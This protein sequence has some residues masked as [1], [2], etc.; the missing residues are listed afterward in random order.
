MIRQQ[1]SMKYIL[2]LLLYLLPTYFSN[3]QQ[4]YFKKWQ[5]I[6]SLEKKGLYGTALEKVNL[7][8]QSASSQNNTNQIIKS[9]IYQLKYN[10]YIAEDDYVLAINHLNTIIPTFQS[11]TK[12]ILH[13]I[14]AEVYYG[15]YNQNQWK[16]S[17]RTTIADDVKIGDIRT[18]DLKRLSQSIIYHYQASLKHE[19]INAAIP[20]KTFDTFIHSP[21]A[22]GFDYYTVYDFLAQRAFSF[23]SNNSF[24]IE[25]PAQTFLIDT[26]DYFGSNTTF[27]NLK[28]TTPDSLN[29]KFYAAQTLQAL[30]I[31][32]TKKNSPFANFQ[33]ALKRLK[34]AKTHSILTDKK[35]RYTEAIKR[36]TINYKDHNFVGEAWYEIANDMY[37]DGIGYTPK[38]SS[39]E[40]HFL[41]KKSALICEEIIMKFPKSLGARQCQSLLSQIKQKELGVSTEATY[42]PNKKANFLIKYRNIDQAYAK[43]VLVDSEKKFNS[44]ELKSFLKNEPGLHLD[45]IVL[46]GSSDYLSHSTEILLP[47]LELGYYYV[48]LSSSVDFSHENSGLAY[49]NFW[50]TKLAYQ[51]KP[52]SNSLVFLGMCRQTGHPIEGAEIK[53]M[54]SYYNRTLSRYAEKTIG[55]YKTDEKGLVTISEI[56]PNQ[57]YFFSMKSGEDYYSPQKSVYYYNNQHTPDKNTRISL[58]TDRKLYRPGQTIYFKGIVVENFQDNNK[59]LPNFETQIS[60]YDVNGEQVESIPLKANEFGS[61]EGQFI[62]PYG[63]LTGAMTIQSS[64]GST[65]VQVEEYKRPKFSCEIDPVKGEYQLNDS[66]LISGNAEAFAGNK[67]SDAKV[68]Y[69]V[70]RTTRYNYWY[71]WFRPSVSKE[72]LNG[73]T[74]TNEKGQFTFKFKAIP[75]ESR[76]PKDLPIFNYTITIDVIDINGETHSSS[77]TFALGYQSLVLSNTIKS[78][79]NINED[80]SFEIKAAS[81]N[82]EALETTGTFEI[83]KLKTP[84]RTYTKRLWSE[85]DQSQWSKTEFYELFPN[86]AYKN[87]NDF[88][89]WPTEKTLLNQAFNTKSKAKITI[90]N[91]AKW[92]PGRYQY[93]AESKDKNGVIVKDIAYF[94]VFDSNSKAPSLNH[95]FNAKLVK[96]TVKPGQTAEVILSSAAKHLNVYYSISSKGKIEHQEWLHLKTEQRKI[97]IPIEDRHIGKVNLDIIV[98]K[99]NRVYNKTLNVNVPKPDTDLKIAFETFRDKLLPGQHEIW[100]ILIK[101]A[102][103]KAAQ[104][105]L[106]ATLYDASLDE[107]FQTNSFNLNLGKAYYQR[108]NWSAPVGFRINSQQNVNYYWNKHK[109]L[110]RR[111]YPYLHYFGY[112]TNNWGYY[113]ANGR[114]DN[115]YAMFDLVEDDGGANEEGA[116]SLDTDSAI[117]GDSGN[118]YKGI[119]IGNNSLGKG[120]S[121]NSNQA[122]PE[123]QSIQARKNFNETAFFYPQLH[124]NAEGEIRIEFDMPESLTKWKFLGLAHTKSLEIGH[125]T[126]E[127]ITQKELMVMPNLPRFLRE[128]DQVELSSKISNLSDTNLN[129]TIFLKLINPINETDIT[130]DF[131]VSEVQKTF[132]VKAD[133][134]TQVTWKIT[135]PKKYS[136]VKYRIMAESPNHN[137]G[138]EDVLPILS[139]RMLVTESMPM[140]MNGKGTKTFKL[141]KLLTNSS[142]SLQHHNLALEFTS[143]PAWYA[144]QAM[145]YMMEYP[146]ECAEQTFTRYYSNAIASHVMNSKPRIKAVIDEWAKTSPDAF[147]SKLNKNQELKAL[148]LEETPW[149]VNAKSES[150]TKRNLAVLLDL[151]RMRNELNTALAKTIQNQSSNGG[152][153]W[154]PGMRTNRYITQHIITGVGHLDVLGIEDAKAN[155]KVVQM[156]KKGVQYLDNQIVSDYER[157]MRKHPQYQKENH[158]SYIQIQYLYARSYFPNLKANKKTQAAIDYFSNQAKTYWLQYNIYAKG[159]IGLAAN[160]MGITDLSTDIYKSLKDNAI[161]HEEFGMYWKSYHVGFYWYEAPVETQALMIEFFSEMKDMNSVEQLKIWLLKEKQTTHWK[162]TKQTSEAVYALLLNGIDLLASEDLVEITIGQKPIQYVS[163]ISDN[164]YDVMPEAGTGYLKTSWPG[165]QVTNEM[166]EVT[167]TKSNS[168]VAWGA[169]YWQYF[170]NLDKITF[171]ETPLKLNKKLYKVNLT[172]SGEELIR[173]TKDNPL[174]IGDK[175]RVRIELRTDRNLEYV[176]MKDMRAAGFEPLNVISSY[177]YQGGLGYYQATKDAATNFFFDYI[178]KGSYVFEYDLRVQQKGNF[179]NGLASIQCMYAPEFTS[180]S[181]GI[182][183]MIK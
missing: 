87:E 150:E 76:D 142:T 136:A 143:N 160:R 24:N 180:H 167:I 113:F 130:A 2:I 48:V 158:L 78:D 21:Y 52:K 59:L 36:L 38:K 134:N 156:I 132:S 161:V 127:L 97:Q 171:H 86:K 125:I 54:Q 84:P 77:Q 138:E 42:L 65:S 73:I 64:Y 60:L 10:R 128:G 3:G 16:F 155:R 92:Q 81:L 50:V 27:S 7:V 49:T 152:W 154:F 115:A 44:E 162:T 147:L 43:I 83:L 124:T 66:I 166:A 105:E 94:T 165:T 85:P 106:L 151:N 13:S 172:S 179:S 170:E 20:I 12:E 144:I 140:P 69:R 82:G 123:V 174:I 163:N 96:K 175:V 35:E 137:D 72:I 15:Y 169:L 178:P 45:S 181:D 32:V 67:I 75:D 182:R 62:A 157:I 183:V 8:Y 37:Q 108:F 5:T 107:L 51:T 100:T 122:N 33:I 89:N 109:S 11:P 164:P 56:D 17:D 40:D 95:V 74:K 103:D 141:F 98:I 80:F 34:F 1:F 58:F 31:S 177:H 63:V 117:L 119:G 148:L 25:G 29:L 173:I 71:W 129:G 131:K 91:F 93:I 126:K 68:I 26:P 46:K 116:Y 90:N 139:N 102:K 23:F 55:T 101:N 104:A 120:K 99:D 118:E 53:M 79:L 168:G 110:P 153:S 9:L 39:D 47:A 18:W 145:P 61:F 176:H 159:M 135:V 114:Q 30:T 70:Q 28:I 112:E 149:V 111:N 57:S 4:T 22:D 41:L 121:S 146:Y 14:L 6:D 19:P 133:G 88:T